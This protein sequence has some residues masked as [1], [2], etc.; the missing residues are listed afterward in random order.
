MNWYEDYN[1]TLSIKIYDFLNDE[2]PTAKSDNNK[3]EIFSYKSSC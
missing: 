2:N 1:E 3:F